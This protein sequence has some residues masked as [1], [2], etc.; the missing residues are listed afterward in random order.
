MS[1]NSLFL[2]FSISFRTLTFNFLNFSISL[3]SDVSRLSNVSGITVLILEDGD[4]YS[5][6]GHGGTAISEKE[7]N[8]PCEEEN[9]Y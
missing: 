2:L 6:K 1:V 3:P 4:I 7:E 9:K 8:D 5:S